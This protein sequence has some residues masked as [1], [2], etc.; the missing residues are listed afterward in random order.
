MS[1]DGHLDRGNTSNGS[2]HAQTDTSIPQRLLASPSAIV[3]V[4]FK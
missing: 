3:N 1:N 4:F 2:R